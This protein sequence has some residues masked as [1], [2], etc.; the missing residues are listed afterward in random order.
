[1]NFTE[2]LPSKQWAALKF[3]GEK[4][5]EVWFKPEGEPHGLTVR[6]SQQSFQMAGLAS[7][8]TIEKLLKAIGI[9][10][11]EVESWRYAD[12]LHSGMNGSNPDFKIT[13]P[14]PPPHASHLEIH[15]RLHQPTAVGS[16]G[17]KANAAPTGVSS[18]ELNAA[19]P[20]PCEEGSAEVSS[21]RWQDLEFRWKAILGLEAAVDT[22]RLSMEALMSEMENSSHKSLT[23]E[24]KNHAPR[25]DIAQ[26]QKA[27]N[28]VHTALPKMRDFIHRATWAMGT[29]ERKRL[30]E[31]YKDHI[32]PQIPFPQMEDVLKQME[33]LQKD[34][35][36]LSAQG[37]AVLQESKGISAEIQG[38]LRMLQGNAAANALRK[39]SATGA[40]RHF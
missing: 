22:L 12:V 5:A 32:Q 13:L 1:M 28:R 2:Q 11:A 3:K 35:Q 27:R 20:P 7:Q 4:F 17:S 31:L 29:P 6:I 37:T 36:V 34:R 30:E 23:M 38:T 18:H 15:I 9:G 19:S 14:P 8:L 10:P 39:K 33:E 24:E 16:Q 25:A 21:T 26:W 40:R